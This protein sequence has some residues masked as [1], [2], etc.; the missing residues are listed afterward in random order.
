MTIPFAT[1]APTS[2][3]ALDSS[4]GL[5]VGAY[6]P[7]LSFSGP[8]VKG[9]AWFSDNVDGN[10]N[11]LFVPDLPRGQNR[12]TSYGGSNLLHTQINLTPSNII[13][14][15][16]LVN[17]NSTSNANLGALD[18]IPTTIDLRTREWFA[19]IKDQVYLTRG[20][21]LE[22]GFSDLR[23]FVRQVPQGDALYVFN[24]NGR[25][26][27]FYVDSTQKSQRK[28]FL[29]NLFLPSFQWLGTHQFKIGVDADRLEYTQDTRRTGFEN[30]GLANNVLRLVTF[31]GSGVLAR[32]SLELSSYIVDNWKIRPNLVVEVG[33]RQD[34]DELV[35]DTVVGAASL[36]L[37]LS[38]RME[39]YEDIG[40]L[41]GPVRY[42]HAAG[43]QPSPGSVFADAR[44][45]IPTAPFNPVPRRQSSP[46]IAEVCRC[47]ATRT[48][49]SVW[50]SCCP[51]EFC[52]A[53][54]FCAAEAATAH[55]RECLESQRSGAS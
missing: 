40:R 16:F 23:T 24:P 20:T 31:A 4:G 2:S 44:S 14:A 35:R 48:G 18:P 36:G 15:D 34:W 33:L 54:I 5:H 37:I 10:Y 11:Q 53:S 7:R 17:L 6:T 29:A 42:Q 43:I 13:F 50:S 12:R 3:P 55:L 19:S 46:L 30:V 49:V 8:I 25:E 28:Q 32:P 39:E 47:R 51:K 22:F 1:P 27:N 45:T 26:G 41:R 9:R 38:L 21:L 52:C